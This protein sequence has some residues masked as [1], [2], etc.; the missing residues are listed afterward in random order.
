MSTHSKTFTGN[1]SG[2]NMVD[3]CSIFLLSPPMGINV[4]I[5]WMT[6]TLIKWDI[7]IL[8]FANFSRFSHRSTPSSN[9]IVSPGAWPDRFTFTSGFVVH[10]K[11]R[12]TGTTG[13]SGRCSSSSSNRLGHSWICFSPPGNMGPLVHSAHCLWVP[14]VSVFQRSFYSVLCNSLFWITGPLIN[15]KMFNWMKELR[16]TGPEHLRVHHYYISFAPLIQSSFE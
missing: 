9:H 6:K 2:V 5:F 7:S 1:S 11:F 4:V 13:P 16:F 12:F 14:P 10:F 3:I 8:F 15:T